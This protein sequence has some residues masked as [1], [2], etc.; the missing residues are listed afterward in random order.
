MDSRRSPIHP[1]RTNTSSRFPSVFA[2]SSS[3][4]RRPTSVSTSAPPRMSRS[5][6]FPF[7]L[8]NGIQTT[9]WV[10]S[11]G[12]ITF[13]AGDRTYTEAVPD[14]ASLPRIAAFFDDLDIRRGSLYINATLPDRFVVTWVGVPHFPQSS[15][16]GTNTLQMILFAYGR[17]QFG[18]RGISSLTTGT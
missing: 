15:T 1:R 18:Y 3:E 10:G 7:P 17:I 8:Y 14:F 6:S 9:A 2:S 4:G 13:G 12:Y 11:N 5:T 16:A